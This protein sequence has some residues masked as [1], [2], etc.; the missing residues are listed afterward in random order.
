MLVWLQSADGSRRPG[1]GF[2]SQ[3]L[4]GASAEQALESVSPGISSLLAPIP[5]G[6]QHFVCFPKTQ[7]LHEEIMA[8]LRPCP[9][10]VLCNLM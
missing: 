9:P 2:D 7:P 5:S 3:W 6:H 10:S 4:A 8:T 1:S